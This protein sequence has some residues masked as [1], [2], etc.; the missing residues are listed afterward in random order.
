MDALVQTGQTRARD[1]TL[2]VS[3]S[4]TSESGEHVLILLQIDA[5]GLAAKGFQKECLSVIEHA[6]L[7]SEG[8]A[9][10]RLDGSLKELN[11]LIKG[12][13]LSK[14][15]KD[16][17]AI[18]AITEKNGT[19]HVSHAGRAE[20]YVVRAGT[21]SQI[22]EYT[23]G[24]PSPAFVHIA[25]G[26]LEERDTIIL[27]T[28]RLLRTVTPAQLAQLS[29]RHHSLLDELKGALE[30]E[31]E[32]AALAI[33]QMEEKEEKEGGKPPSAIR[34]RARQGKKGKGEFLSTASSFAMGALKKS[35]EIIRSISKGRK[36]ESKMDKIKDWLQSFA[37]DLRDP[38]RKRRAHMILIAAVI[39]LFLV[40]WAITNLTSF[41]QH[42]QS[43]AELKQLVEEIN[44]DIRSAENRRLT[45]DTESANA[46][47]KRAE[48]QAK[49]VIGNEGGYFRKEAGEILARIQATKEKIN[50]LV[51]LSPRMVVN[52][53]VENPNVKALGFIGLG[54]E[55][56]IAYDKQDIYRIIYNNLDEPDRIG[57][58]EL[59]LN[60]VN[61]PRYETQVF[62]T[63]G[64]GIIEMIAG[65]PTS[66]KT[67]D[68]SG[69]VAGKDM[70]SYLRFLYI[71]SPENNQ[72]YKYERLSNRYAAPDEYNVSGDLDGALD[73]AIDGNIYILKEGGEVVNL[74]RGEA[75]PFVIR[76]APEEVLKNATKVFKV[77]DGHLYF[78]DPVRS[79]VIIAT[80]GGTSGE[81][82]YIKQYVLESDEIGELQDL[83]V[84][85]DESRLY[86]MD[87]KRIYK[88]DL[89]AM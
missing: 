10:Q 43:K 83:Y 57:D 7:E 67:E 28:Q 12:L 15:I 39:A 30:A 70:E 26:Q 24:K 53:A 79:R 1:D 51:R 27:S 66:M 82:S 61:F 20:A 23:R 89:G 81:A 9:S 59:L 73:M 45:G 37:K 38:A 68:P 63:T 75:Q 32:Q 35:G 49:Q 2:L 31:K 36:P 33:M 84:D 60:G 74:L 78:L 13:L 16:F 80:D 11:G 52:L 88:I 69:W 22:T 64:N 17:H 6:L 4:L 87:E 62:Q 5:E 34:S 76:H 48:E 85:P 58:E 40:V 47:L 77:F 14:T 50:N 72:I 44:N 54:E 56:F 29:T 55:E 86:V 65:Q 3:K 25:S 41:S 8:E 21:A 19:L 42:S 46:I 71:L 18:I